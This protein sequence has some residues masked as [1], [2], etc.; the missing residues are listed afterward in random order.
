MCYTCKSKIKQHVQ[1]KGKKTICFF[2]IVEPSECV[3][4]AVIRQDE[5]SHYERIILKNGKKKSYPL[6]A[7]LLFHNY[8]FRTR[9]ELTL[10]LLP[11]FSVNS[12]VRCFFFFVEYCITFLLLYILIV[13]AMYMVGF[14][15]IL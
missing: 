5:K 7:C 14:I 15:L 12:C 8:V 4:F 13:K 9:G 10:M 2:C 11:F 6:N 3:H 1:E